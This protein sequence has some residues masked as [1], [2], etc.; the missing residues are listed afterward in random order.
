MDRG[1]WQSM[2]SQRVRLDR[3]SA[4]THRCH[5]RYCI[6]DEVTLA[7]KGLTVSQVRELS[8]FENMTLVMILL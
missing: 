8:V 3:V 4:H 6:I 5:Y 1:V 2:G 7:W